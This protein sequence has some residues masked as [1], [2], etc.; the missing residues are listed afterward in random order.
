LAARDL[1]IIEPEEARDRIG[2]TLTTLAGME[3]P[4]SQRPVLTTGTTRR[5][6]AKLTIWPPTG[7]PVYPFLSTVDNGWLAT[8]LIMVTHAVPQLARIKRRPSSTDELWLLL[9]CPQRL[10]KG[11]YWPSPP[12]NDCN[13][14]GYTCFD[15][16]TLKH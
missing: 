6:G 12:P 3:P 9:Q 16:G 14:N 13:D 15:F 7:G 4:R 10:L 1:Q 11:G 2:Q 8:A 5:P